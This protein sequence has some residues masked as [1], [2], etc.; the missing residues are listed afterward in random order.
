MYK[1][2]AVIKALKEFVGPE[3]SYRIISPKSKFQGNLG[4][5]V[6]CDRDFDK[7]LE[8]LLED[9]NVI[10]AVFEGN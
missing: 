3:I 2:N 9:E 10:Y 5:S 4:I 6:I 7:N 1:T 8:K